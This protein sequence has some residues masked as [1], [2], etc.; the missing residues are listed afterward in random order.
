MSFL[1]HHKLKFTTLSPVHIGCNEVYEPTNYVIEGDTLYEFDSQAATRALNEKDR[2][3]LLQTVSKKGDVAMLKAVQGFFHS[4]RAELISASDHAL[5]VGSGIADMY[6]ARIG[7]TAHTESGGGKRINQL[8]IERTAHNP[9]DFAPILPGSSIKGSIRTAL[10]DAVNQGRDVQRGEKNREMQQRLFEYSMRDLHKDPMRLVRL[11]DARWGAET[12]LP[13]TEVRFA[14]NRKKRPVTKDGRE[15]QSMADQKGLWQQLECVPAGV[16][17]GLDAQLSIQ[18]VGTI[19]GRGDKLPSVDLRWKAADIAKACNRFYLPLFKTETGILRERGYIDLKWLRRVESI[20]DT[21]F[22]DRLSE[23]RA[24]LVRAGR[25]SGAEAVS[26]NGVRSIRIMQ[27]KGDKKYEK[28]ARTLWLAAERPDSKTGLLP[29]GWLLVE[30]DPDP[31][32][33]TLELAFEGSNETAQRWLAD[34]ET[35]RAAQREERD[36]NR[37][38]QAELEREEQQRLEAEAGRRQ[39]FEDSLAGQSQM[40]RELLTE[41]RD[42]KWS[43][44]KSAFLSGDLIESWLTRLEE[45]PDGHV[46][47]ELARFVNKHIVGLLKDPDKLKGKKKKPAF[48]DRQREIARRLLALLK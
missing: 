12:G 7:K 38:H 18:D 26:L 15:L 46:A 22:A 10:L 44:D 43:D 11:G 33:P 28:T 27:G 3:R 30:I 4:K 9:V 45:S 32:D 20:L 6:E 13:P 48:S 42:G 16:A 24:F 37:A 47:Q 29:F 40:M 17:R 23:G 21:G 1:D 8:E 2:A 36:R 31:G 25:H 34:L 41:A 14:V 5:P 35:R 19:E 39:A